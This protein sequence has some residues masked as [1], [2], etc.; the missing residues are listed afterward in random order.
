MVVV[1]IIYTTIP[2]YLYYVYEI[3]LPVRTM[4]P[5]VRTKLIRSNGNPNTFERIRSRFQ[6]SSTTPKT[7][8]ITNSNKHKHQFQSI[9]LSNIAK[10]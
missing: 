6:S 9:Q 2:N 4:M 3:S 7:P 1:H 5:Y 8:L 10:Y